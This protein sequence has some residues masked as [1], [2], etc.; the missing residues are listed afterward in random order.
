MRYDAVRL[1]LGVYAATVRVTNTGSSTVDGWTLGWAFIGGDRVA[2]PIGASVTQS[3]P[4]VSARNATLNK[5]IRPGASV[6]F[7]VLGSNSGPFD[8]GL[9]TLNGRP[10]TA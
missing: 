6:T 7:A 9:F 3:G 1:P 8:P 2:L 4:W 10:C 5:R